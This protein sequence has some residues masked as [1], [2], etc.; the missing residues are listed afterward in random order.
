[1]LI[2]NKI[3]DKMDKT[4]PFKG[5]DAGKKFKKLALATGQA[6]L[7]LGS[8]VIEAIVKIGSTIDRLKPDHADSHKN[9]TDTSSVAKVPAKLEKDVVDTIAKVLSTLNDFGKGISDKSGKPANK[10]QSDF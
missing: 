5:T 3:A 1:M 7:A 8:D 6:P 9:K 4:P 2:I 10:D